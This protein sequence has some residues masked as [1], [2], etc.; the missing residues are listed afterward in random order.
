MHLAFLT[1]EYPHP[2][3]TA[4]AGLGTSIKN[5]AEALDAEGIKITVFIYGQKKSF[6]P[7]ENNIDLHFIKQKKYAWLGWYRYRKFLE[8][9]LNKVIKEKEIDAIEAA[10]WTGI[11]SFM[12]LIC[13][14]VIRLHGSDTYFCKLEDRKQKWKNFWLEKQGLKNADSLISVSEFTSVKTKEFFNLNKEIQVIPNFID[15][16]T[17][18]P[19][20][21]EHVPNTILY[22]GSLIRKK[23][24]LELAEIFN[25]VIQR[26]PDASLKLAGRDVRDAITGNSTLEMF[27]KQ[28]SKEA[29][30]KVQ[31]LGSLSY[32]Y[33][34][35]E[36]TKA[37]VIVLPSFAEA[38][39][40]TWLEAMAMEKSLVTSNIG[41][42]HEIMVD[43]KT[44]YMVDPLDHRSY[45]D[46][47]LELLADE[48]LNSQFGKAARN[49][50]IEDFT[51]EKVIKKNIVFYKRLIPTKV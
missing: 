29:S 41:W 28:L 42:A 20:A 13:P 35:K 37:S 22:F 7:S 31:Y 2:E 26:N 24:L 12:N 23:G 48:Q 27:Y 16:Q 32:E 10:D 3:S 40:M 44:G 4:Y 51:A 49:K 47:I 39:P 9:Y 25:L 36:I 18:K 38:L 1:P 19:Q 5:L 46:R 50:I 43:A 17:F 45:A 15:T 11:T 21:E 34:K 14:L 30:A 6:L 8:S 33:L